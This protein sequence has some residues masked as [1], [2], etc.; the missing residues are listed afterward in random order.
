MQ[1][2]YFSAEKSD[3]TQRVGCRLVKSL[4]EFWRIIKIYHYKH[5]T[6]ESIVER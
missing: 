5:V 3:G 1:V 4:R 2:V 6:I